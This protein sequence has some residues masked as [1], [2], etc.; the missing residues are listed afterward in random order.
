VSKDLNEGWTVILH[1]ECEKDQGDFN[2]IV[3]RG[4]TQ[5]K[6][7]YVETW[8]KKAENYDQK[9]A[10]LKELL[11]RNDIKKYFF[12]QKFE[13]HRFMNLGIIEWNN[14]CMDARTCA[15][16]LDSEL[17]RDCS[18]EDLIS[19][20]TASSQS[21]KGAVSDAEKADMLLLLR[22]DREKFVKY[23]SLDP[24]YTLQ[25]CI[26]LRKELLK[27]QK[28]L[29]YF[30][31]FAQPIE[32][33]FL[34]EMERNGVLVDRQKIPEIKEKLNKEIRDKEKQFKKYCPPIV[35]HR[36]K[37]NFKLTR[38]IIL[39]EALFE[40]TDKKAKKG[41]ELEHHDYG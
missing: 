18:L 38:T 32:N 5:K 28:S 34:F 7:E 25:V 10:E 27:D 31:K 3:Q 1:E 33:E 12:N 15:H 39:Q 17:Y 36:H 37:D 23:A 26:E 19:Q 9:V 11:E 13:Q 20:F 16:V 6:P 14:C 24:V 8:V 21:H 40:W 29:N 30:I 22:T 35:Y 2:I 4:G 41:K